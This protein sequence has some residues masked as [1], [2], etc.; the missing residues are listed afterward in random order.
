MMVLPALVVIQ[1]KAQIVTNITC[2][3][4]HLCGRFDCDLIKHFSLMILLDLQ[5]GWID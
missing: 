4:F 2:V 1:T 3:L 5:V